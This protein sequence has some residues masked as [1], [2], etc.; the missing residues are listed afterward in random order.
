MGPCIV[1]II[2]FIRAVEPRDPSLDLLA[3]VLNQLRLLREHGLPGTFLLQYDSLIEPRFL[4]PLKEAAGEEIEL[5]LWLETMQPLVEKA[6][7]PW[8]GRPGF[9]W[10]WHANVGFSVGYT[11]REREALVD[12]CMRDFRERL[13]RYPDSVGSWI[14]DA[15]TLAYCADRYGVSGSCNCRDQWGTDGYTIWGGYFNQ[16]YYPSRKN[17]LAPA[18]TKK[19]G[20]P[21]PVFR[22]LGSD[23]L[24]QYDAGFVEGESLG[25]GQPV[26]TLEPV[27]PG[28]GGDP[29]WVR[30][31]FDSLRT[32]PNLSFGYTQVGQENSFGW[33]A[34]KAGLEDQMALVARMRDAG[35]LRV[36]CLRDSAR[37]YRKRWQKTPSSAFAALVDWKGKGRRSLWYCSRFYRLNLF[38]EGEKVWIRDMHLF[39]EDYPERYLESRCEGGELVYDNLP[40]VDGARWSGHGVRAGMRLVTVALGG[41]AADVTDASCGEPAVREES[42]EELLASWPVA[43]GGSC[44]VRCTAEEV[45]VSFPEPASGSAWGMLMTWDPAADAPL[46]KLSDGALRFFHNDWEYRLAVH[47]ILTS[48]SGPG[49]ILLVA[50]G[51]EMRLRPQSGR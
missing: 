47:G 36:E 24:Y 50:K 38:Q 3:P 49:R 13:G 4:E 34:M 51:R 40:I 7:L 14:I 22:M 42:G 32:S 16:A 43:T 8:R 27:Y 5:G 39:D 21:V 12:V 1:N 35:E 11:P 23:P 6:G 45:A 26:V 19:A 9:S 15:H 28:A 18:Q 48:R 17:V 25:N 2:N 33:P 31:F 20:I 44:T 46:R 10:D 29:R 37:W 30:W 41:E